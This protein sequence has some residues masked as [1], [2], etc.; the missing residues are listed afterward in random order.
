M[1]KFDSKGYW[2]KT[3]WDRYYELQKVP[4]Q[5]RKEFLNQ[6]ELT[7]SCISS[8]AKHRE[9]I[10]VLDLACGTGRISESIL[11][12]AP[13]KIHITL[14]DFNEN[15]IMKARERLH[16]YK[17]I[18]Y[19][20]LDVYDLGSNFIEKYDVIVAMDIFHHISDLELFI[21][22]IH[23]ALKPN[24]VLI[25]NAFDNAKYKEW[26]KLKYGNLTSLKRRM[27]HRISTAFYPL[28]PSGLKKKITDNGYARIS[29]LTDEIISKCIDTFFEDLHFKR[30]YYLWFTAIKK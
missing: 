5:V 19:V 3:T 17:N 20:L 24:G 27:R 22:Q 4:D 10:N 16:Q 9:K 23:I 25:A 2:K 12:S 30:S 13:E 28:M 6:E 26:D 15:T 1:I 11:N 18:D 21:K 14:L 8:L 29:P 7:I